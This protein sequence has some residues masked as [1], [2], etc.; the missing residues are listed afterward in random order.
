METTK[1]YTA[2]VLTGWHSED[3]S[4]RETSVECG[5][6]HKTVKAAVACAKSH[7]NSRYVNGS[8]TASAAWHNW[9]VISNQQPVDGDLI[10]KAEHEIEQARR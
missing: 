8:W 10:S 7:Y 4:R 1:T 9:T 6:K 5:H 2:A 3:Y